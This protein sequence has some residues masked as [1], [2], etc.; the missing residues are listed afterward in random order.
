MAS[1]RAHAPSAA[2]RMEGRAA[3]ELGVGMGYL[4][5]WYLVWMPVPELAPELGLGSRT[6]ARRRKGATAVERRQVAA[7]QRSGETNPDA[8]T[9]L[10]DESR[11]GADRGG[12][13]VSARRVGRDGLDS[14]GRGVFCCRSRAR[15]L[16]S[17]LPAVDCQA[18][19]RPGDATRRSGP[20]AVV[21]SRLIAHGSLTPSGLRPNPME[22]GTGTRQRASRRE[23]SFLRSDKEHR[24]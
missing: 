21:F 5:S 3:M 12:S 2:S 6:A 7:A 11:G 4:S 1:T 10:Y 14:G 15:C 23:R 20:R 22:C 13:N 8:G 17:G 19:Y 24:G 18:G 16:G 9:G